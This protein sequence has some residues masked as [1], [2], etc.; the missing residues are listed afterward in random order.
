MST[1]RCSTLANTSPDRP[2]LARR[3]LEEARFR[4]GEERTRLEKE[5]AEVLAS[6]RLA[7]LLCL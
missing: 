7:D 5:A 2:D 3:E 1:N 4:Q 6:L